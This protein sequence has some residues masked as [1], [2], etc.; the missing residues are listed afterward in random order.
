MWR[1]Y[2]VIF[3]VTII[4]S[5]LMSQIVANPVNVSEEKNN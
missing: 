4:V 2:L 1:S 3:F 5:L